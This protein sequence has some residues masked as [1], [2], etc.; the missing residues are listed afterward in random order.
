[1]TTARLCETERVEPPGDFANL[2]AAWDE[3]SRGNRRDILKDVR[4]ARR[5]QVRADA[6]LAAWAGLRELR[7]QPRQWLLLVLVQAV[8][9]AV[10]FATLDTVIEDQAF[11]LAT[12]SPW[13]RGLPLALACNLGQLAV[14]KQL[15]RGITLNARFAAGEPVTGPPDMDEAERLLRVMDR[16]GWLRYHLEREGEAPARS[17]QG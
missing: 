10:V 3:L 9:M 12:A 8:L 15:R 17:A 5:T 13:L 2:R 6:A 14:R 7:N 16:E 1:M 4:R 11:T